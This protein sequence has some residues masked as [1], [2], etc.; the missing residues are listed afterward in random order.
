MG[1]CHGHPYGAY[2]AF[3]VCQSPQKTKQKKA[4]RVKLACR[5][6]QIDAAAT[7]VSNLTFSSNNSSQN[8]DSRVSA[9]LVESPEANP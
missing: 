7:R 9:I 2:G 5:L 4:C 3:G 8:K 6:K 1:I